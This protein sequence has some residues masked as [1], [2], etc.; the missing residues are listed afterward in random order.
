MYFHFTYPYMYCQPVI[1]IHSFTQKFVEIF[2]IILLSS[3]GTLNGSSHMF[4]IS[5][6][7]LATK[8]RPG[9]SPDGFFIRIKLSSCSQHLSGFTFAVSTFVSYH[10]AIS[11]PRTW[12]SFM[13]CSALGT[14]T[15]GTFSTA[16]IFRRPL[17]NI[18]SIVLPIAA[19]FF[20]SRML[21]A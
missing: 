20:S 14:S 21:P 2:C 7:L 17:L 9:F 1:N 15:I 16:G 18:D 19:I 13:R 8:T 3:R 6:F 10:S 5:G 11:L 4:P 12:R